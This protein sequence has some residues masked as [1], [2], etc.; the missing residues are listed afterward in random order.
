MKLDL[1]NFEQQIHAII[2]DRGKDYL[3]KGMVNNLEQTGDGWTANVQ[4]GEPYRVRLVGASDFESWHC[5]C[6]FDHGPVCKHVSAVI[7]AI[8]HLKVYEQEEIQ[9]ANEYIEKL[10]HQEKLRF[11]HDAF[12]AFPELRQF[13]LKRYYKSISESE[14]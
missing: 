4:S 9:L 1:E 14:E 11:M 5:T 2:L 6:P 3:L 10:D 8:H 7:Y 12:S 13:F